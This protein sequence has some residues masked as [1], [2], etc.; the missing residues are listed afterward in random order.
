ML[1]QCGQQCQ[2]PETI[3]QFNLMQNYIQDCPQDDDNSLLTTQVAQQNSCVMTS[4]LTRRNACKLQDPT[5]HVNI[6]IAAC[7]NKAVKQ[8]KSLEEGGLPP[9]L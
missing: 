3:V 4:R 9:Q 5:K 6:C 7:S 2:L 1:V 8:Y